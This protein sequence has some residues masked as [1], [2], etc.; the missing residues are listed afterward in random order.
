[1]DC[2]GFA[3]VSLIY[4]GVISGVQQFLL[5]LSTDFIG[6]LVMGLMASGE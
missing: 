1:M 4:A 3:V 6:E 2:S 5:L